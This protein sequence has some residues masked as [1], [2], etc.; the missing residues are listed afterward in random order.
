V[1]G[2]GRILI[3]VLVVGA[4]LGV[5]VWS[6]Q[7]RPPPPPPV[8]APVAAPAPKPPPPPDVAPEPAIRHPIEAA[9][10]KGL[11]ALDDADGY[12]RNALGELL[13][14]KALSLLALD[15][16]VRRFVATV[17]NLGREAA[18]A[19][20][21]PVNP[22]PGV[23]KAETDAGGAIAAQNA[24]RYAPLVALAE[25][26]DTRR[27]VALYV[28]LYPLCQQAYEELGYPGKYF[29]DRLVEVIDDLL[30][31]PDVPVP[32]KVRAVKANAPGVPT[33]YQFEDPALEAL[34]AGRKVLLRVGA[35]NARRL[36][37]KLA[38]VRGQ[39]ARKSLPSSHR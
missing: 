35:D 23:F 1:N 7:H 17:D 16:F 32:I 29:N 10:G 37:A 21:W 39:I 28:R 25:A 8:V 24:Q 4:L 15:G 20:L 33:L 6:R 27:A 3:V 18:P 22:T 12:V 36:K 2:G 38:D 13:G 11:P 9:G 19:R 14:R 30:A 34:P 31:T 5:Y 26:M